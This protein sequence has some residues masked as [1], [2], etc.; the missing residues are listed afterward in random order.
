MEG[1]LLKRVRQHRMRVKKQ[2]DQRMLRPQLLVWRKLMQRRWC[3]RM[4][5]TLVARQLKLRRREERLMWMPRRLLRQ[6]RARR[7]WV[8]VDLLRKLRRLRRR[9]QRL[10]VRHLTNL[11]VRLARRLA[12][13][14]WLLALW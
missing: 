2:V 10:L 6:L 11:L 7:C 5:R 9:R 3:L 14:C 13:R 4:H 8:L 1:V 12:R